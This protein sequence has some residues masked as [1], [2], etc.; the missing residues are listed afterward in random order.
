MDSL[1][2]DADTLIERLNGAG[3]EKAWI[4]SNAYWFG[5]PFTQVEN[6][7]ERVKEQN[8]WI[9][10]QAARYPE[11]LDAFMSINPLKPY[12]LKEIQRCADS[13]N[14][15]GIKVHLANS[16]IDLSD[17][18]HLS[19]L[20]NVFT[21]AAKNQLILLLH[22]RNDKDWNGKAN[23]E[24]LLKQLL[25]FAKDSRIVLA[26]MGGWG[27]FDKATDKAL[28]RFRKYL[29]KKRYSAT[30]IYF[31]LSAVV[32]TRGS[33]EL[34]STKPK[35]GWNAEAALKKRINQ[36]GPSHILFGTDFPINE[37]D[38]YVQQLESALGTSTLQAILKNNVD[39]SH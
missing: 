14:F 27:G 18:A 10:E 33:E 37:I 22:F 17:D 34:Q 20:Q 26:H 16:K 11:R 23:T 5:S 38:A 32:P 4:L 30:N 19:Q 28:N 21:L 7:Y 31:D 8:D 3:F 15:V 2:L 9:A 39:R 12:A 35:S 29:K 1:I 13:H 36:I 6:E 24:I 25:P